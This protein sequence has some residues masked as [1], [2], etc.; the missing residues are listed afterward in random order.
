M[1]RFTRSCSVR[2][3]HAIFVLD[4]KNKNKEAGD[5]LYAS[6]H[7]ENHI[8]D[9]RGMEGYEYRRNKPDPESGR[10]HSRRA[11]LAD[12]VHNLRQVRDDREPDA[13]KTRY[14]TDFK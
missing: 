9:H 6:Q 8:E 7:Q 13:D 12:Q 1:D 10:T 4:A 2:R 11:S 3:T 5:D 14:R